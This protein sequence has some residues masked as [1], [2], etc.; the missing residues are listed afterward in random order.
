MDKI[1]LA[2]PEEINGIKDTA[3]LDF[4]QAVYAMGEPG[5]ADLAVLKT[6]PE[7]D[8]AVFRDQTDTRRKV[9]FLW[10]LENILRV[11]GLK[12]YYFNADA[13]DQKWRKVIDSWGAEQ[14]SPVEEIRY[15]RVL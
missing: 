9:Q 14:L 10:G 11:A 12:A 8:P 7:L 15:K 4:A 5:E 6:V 3:D 1:R 13:K 2:T